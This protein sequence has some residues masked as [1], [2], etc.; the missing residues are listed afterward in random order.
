MNVTERPLVAKMREN[1]R[2]FGGLSLL[3]GIIFAFC[4]YK[5]MH[6]ITFPI[7]V[8]VTIVFAVL[9]LKKINYR[10]MKQSLPYI[11][12]M[13]LLSISTVF[14][15][16]FF[17]HFF[18]LAGII[19]LFFV[20]MIH[21]FYNDRDWN[22]PAYLKRIFI[23]AGTVMESIPKPYAHGAEYLGGSKNKKNHIFIAIAIGL[24]IAIGSLC[25]ILPLLL[26]SDIIFAKF[27]GE[28]LKYINFSTIFGIALTVVIGFTLSYA[29]FCGLCKYNFPEGKERRRKYYNPVIGITFTSVISFIYLIYCLIQIMYLFIGIQKGLP[30]DVTYAQYARTGF[31]ELLT[32]GMINFVMVLLCMYLFQDHIAMKIILT[33]I[34]GCTFIMLFS[35]AYRMMMYIGAYHLTF[36]RILVLW[37]LI[38]LALIMGGIIIS[39]YKGRF[40]LFRYIMGVVSILYIGLAFSRPEVVAAKY[41]IAHEG[42]LKVEDVR[43]MMSQMSIDVAPIIAGIDPRSDVDYTSKGI[44]ENADNLEQSMYYY[45]SDIAQGNEGIFFR[46][47]NYS[48]IRAKLAADKYLELNDRGEEYDFE[49]GDYKY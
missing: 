20:F 41:N 39:I 34:S 26:N 38:V 35:A 22:F 36:L 3:Y 37:F 8:A 16:S 43:Y 14:T 5:N 27:F 47:A 19:L 40:P 23:L 33:I 7:C 10:I 11:A 31:W 25:V 13:I 42:K 6:G 45:F 28:M 1:Y 49:Y 2:Y 48:R 32:V 9:F 44:Y 18:N 17:L 15:S 30:S 4:L 29:F 46:K 12:G 21:Q 24:C